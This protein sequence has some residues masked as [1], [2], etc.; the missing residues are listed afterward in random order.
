MMEKEIEGIS[1]CP[2]CGLTNKNIKGMIVSL[3]TCKRIENVEDN[4]DKV[5]L[6]NRELDQR[7]EKLEESKK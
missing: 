1:I 3:C 5:M 4:I 6:E 2:K 7:V